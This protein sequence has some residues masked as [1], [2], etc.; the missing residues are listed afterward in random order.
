MPP[1]PL[2][3][4]CRRLILVCHPIFRNERLLRVPSGRAEGP[5]RALGAQ[6][7]IGGE[8]GEDAARRRTVP[9]GNAQGVVP[10]VRAEEHGRGEAFF[11]FFHF[12]LPLPLLVLGV[13]AG[14]D[15]CHM[16]SH[17]YI[18]AHEETVVC[19]FQV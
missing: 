2:V 17:A 19:H 18:R 15:V 12:F 14:G 4:L 1:S 5:V 7:R 10:R 3:G 9:S 13:G 16:T 6:N 8:R 11:F